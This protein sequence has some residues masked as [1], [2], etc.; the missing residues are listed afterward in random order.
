MPKNFKLN[1][2]QSTISFKSFIWNYHS[3][4]DWKDFQS[5]M[6]GKPTKIKHWVVQTQ[7]QHEQSYIFYTKLLIGKKNYGGPPAAIGI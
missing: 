5:Q 7:Q 1:L 6:L 4:Q 2:S 3:Q